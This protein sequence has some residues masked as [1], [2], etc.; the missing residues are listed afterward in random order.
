MLEKTFLHH[1]RQILI[2]N[3]HVY[4]IHYKNL[5][6]CFTAIANVE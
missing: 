5:D 2:Y 6:T 1:A 4:T 3:V